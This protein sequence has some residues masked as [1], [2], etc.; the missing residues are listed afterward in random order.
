MVAIGIVRG[1]EARGFAGTYLTLAGIAALTVPAW[2]AWR[3]HVLKL[4]TLAR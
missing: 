1:G 3:Q 2:T 4:R